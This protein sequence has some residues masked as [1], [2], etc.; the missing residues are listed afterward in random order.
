MDRV[1]QFIGEIT[2]QN[3]ADLDYFLGRA[4]TTVAT[5]SSDM[6]LVGRVSSS[7]PNNSWRAAR[8]FEAVLASTE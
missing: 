4:Q 8:N 1:Q 7:D 2:A 5:V 3:G 6:A